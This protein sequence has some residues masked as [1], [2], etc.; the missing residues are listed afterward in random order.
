VHRT[1]GFAHLTSSNSVDIC[2]EDSAKL[3][4]VGK[5]GLP[6]ALILCDRFFSKSVLFDAVEPKETDELGRVDYAPGSLLKQLL[7]LGRIEDKSGDLYTGGMGTFVY[8]DD[9]GSPLDF[10]CASI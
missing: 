4:N 10:A 9:C 7:R 6:R 3:T 8:E 5:Y 1:A 2:D